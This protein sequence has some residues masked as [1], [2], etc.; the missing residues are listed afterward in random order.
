MAAQDPYASYTAGLTAPIVGAFAITP[1]NS[2]D[3]PKVTRQIYAGGAG[4]VVVVWADGSETT[5]PVLAGERLD[6][7]IKQVKLTGTTATGL[8]GYY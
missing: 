3:L 1:S 7:R 6:W 4:N 2:D 5:E 8:R